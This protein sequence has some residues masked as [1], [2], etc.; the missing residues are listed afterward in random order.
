[1]N[2][3]IRSQDRDL[4]KYL[5]DRAQSD[6]NRFAREIEY[7][8]GAIISKQGDKITSFM[9]VIEGELA[10][11]SES[12]KIVGRVYTGE[13][14]NELHYIK[15]H[16]ALCDIRAIR[17]SRVAVIA[18]IDMD[19]FVSKDPERAARIQAAINDSLCLKNIRLT[20]WED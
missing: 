17:P 11:A 16:L 2:I 14:V 18:F 4:C 9:V 6:L 7:P 12:G 5:D 19:R 10:L 13:M 15:D 8:I 1:V 3:Y 20:H